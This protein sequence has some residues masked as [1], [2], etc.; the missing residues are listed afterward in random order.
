IIPISLSIP[1]LV[2]RAAIYCLRAVAMHFLLA[3]DAL[4]LSMNLRSRTKME[5]RSEFL[6]VLGRWQIRSEISLR[7][8]IVLGIG[9]FM[10]VIRKSLLSASSQ[11]LKL[12]A[13]SSIFTKLRSM[14]G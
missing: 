10:T 1:V 5:N 14:L 13:R 9:L 7:R 12:I 6:R 2:F 3:A 4:A 11:W 8:G